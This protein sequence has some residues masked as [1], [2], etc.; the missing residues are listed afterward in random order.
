MLFDELELATFRNDDIY[1][2]K[3]EILSVIIGLRLKGIALEPTCSF[4]RGSL[5]SPKGGDCNIRKSR[6][7]LCKLWANDE[8]AEITKKSYL[9]LKN[10]NPLKNYILL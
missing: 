2:V 9:C 7:N 4:L 6:E 5:N 3:D 1:L 10:L 8:R